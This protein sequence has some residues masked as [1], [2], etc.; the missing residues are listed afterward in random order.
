LHLPAQL[1]RLAFMSGR[2]RRS[3]NVHLPEHPLR[4][5]LT[6][7]QSSALARMRDVLNEDFLTI[8]L[9]RYSLT[10][11]LGEGRVRFAGVALE[12][13]SGAVIEVVGE[14]VG[15]IDA[16]FVGL[17]ERYAP[18]HPSLRALRF[19]SFAVRG[20]MQ[21]S[22]SGSATDAKAEATI[23]VTNS[24]G[25]EFSFR[26]V[27]SSVTFSCLDSVLGAVEYFLNSERAFLRISAALDHY[28]REGRP[29]LVSKYT[30]L[31]AE[32]VRNTSYSAL[33]EKR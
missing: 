10:E 22:R 31:L 1:H 3:L 6:H 7:Q 25:A 26:A 29:D 33:V 18:E 14:G 24:Y 11:D 2:P 21:E 23:G 32:M 13:P 12:R 30:D 17:I 8:E 27:S 16:F 15:L 5:V 4:D 28:R 20:L 19:T 9:Q